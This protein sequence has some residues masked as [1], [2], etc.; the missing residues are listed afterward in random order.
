MQTI[1]YDQIGSI[2][3]CE[4]HF[5][6]LDA[7]MD[8]ALAGNKDAEADVI[9]CALHFYGLWIEDFDGD[10]KELCRAIRNIDYFLQGNIK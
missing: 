9:N 10:I 5:Y 7:L 6:E 2:L 1:H 8:K 4:K 3:E